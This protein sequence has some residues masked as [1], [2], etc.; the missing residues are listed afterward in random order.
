ML[1]S[2]Q[3]QDFVKRN[4]MNLEIPFLPAIQLLLNEKLPW[5]LP[6]QSPFL[7]YHQPGKIKKI[8]LSKYVFN[9]NFSPAH[10]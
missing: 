8:Y 9:F 4:K 10:A 2:V 7:L 1:K 5:P 3:L 6:F